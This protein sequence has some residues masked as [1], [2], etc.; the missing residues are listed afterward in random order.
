MCLFDNF[1]PIVTVYGISIPFPL[2]IYTHLF[3]YYYE[4]PYSAYTIHSLKQCMIA[5]IFDNVLKQ[6]KHFKIKTNFIIL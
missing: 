4:I 1:L 2:R 3:W 5:S 6:N